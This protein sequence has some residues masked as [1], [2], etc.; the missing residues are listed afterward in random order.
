MAAQLKIDADLP[1]SLLI[2][3][4]N[5]L[6]RIKLELKFHQYQDMETCMIKIHGRLI[7]S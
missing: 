2:L 3:P 1:Y 6:N 7:Q 4:Y 5:I